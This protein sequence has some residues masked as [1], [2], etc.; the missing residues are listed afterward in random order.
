[1]N[2]KKKISL[3]ISAVMILSAFSS[4]GG[5]TEDTSSGESVTTLAVSDTDAEDIID[6]FGEGYDPFS[7]DYDP[8][9]GKGAS[10][11]KQNPETSP[12]GNVNEVPAAEGL[13]ETAAQGGNTS[14]S[15]GNQTTAPAT[16]NTGSN[17][18]GN[19]NTGSGSSAPAATT[20]AQTSG[21]TSSSGTTAAAEQS[22]DKVSLVLNSSNSWEN[23]SDKFT[24][25]D[26][27]VKNNSDKAIGNWTVTISA[28]SGVKVDQYWNCNISV[29]GGTLTVTPVDYNSFVDVGSEGTFGMIL[30]NAGSID[31][32]KASVKFGNTTVS[33]SDYWN[34]NNN[35][36]NNGGGGGS[37]GNNSPKIVQAKDVPAPTTDDWLYT[38]GS[39]IVDKDGKEVWLTGINWFGYNTGTNTFDGL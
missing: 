39:K 20:A 38:D 3:L 34:G 23:G 22:S 36:N 21:N 32:S 33:G 26:G 9:G 18:G 19:G 24:Q 2:I 1:M 6:F 15:G 17:S 7:D 16:Q 35:N 14:S 13:S 31:S 25:L 37:V 5:N 11:S 28:A 30:C 4:C 8:Y 12:G 29:S 10:A 27:T